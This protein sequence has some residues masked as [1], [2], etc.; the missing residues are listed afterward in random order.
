MLKETGVRSGVIGTV[1]NVINDK[2]LPASYTTP[3][4]KIKPTFHADSRKT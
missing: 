1:G 4:V 3:G 2:K